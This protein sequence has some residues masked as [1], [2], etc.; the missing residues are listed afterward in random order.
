MTMTETSREKTMPH[1]AA[2][3]E[4]M[5]RLG[6]RRYGAQGGDWGSTISREL[7]LA[8]PGVAAPR[9]EVADGDDRHAE[10]RAGNRSRRAR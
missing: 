3:D 7:G 5:R 4:L 6:Y 1:R 10:R 9:V 8:G 2:W